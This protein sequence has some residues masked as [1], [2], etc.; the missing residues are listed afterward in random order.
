MERHGTIFINDI[1]LVMTAGTITAGHVTKGLVSLAQGTTH[2]SILA[3]STGQID[4]EIVIAEGPTATIS[5][6][7]FEADSEKR[8]IILHNPMIAF[9][10]RAVLYYESRKELTIKGL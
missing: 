1:G 3:P 2:A 5:L 8:T 4:G 6:G 10:N 7:D 9:W